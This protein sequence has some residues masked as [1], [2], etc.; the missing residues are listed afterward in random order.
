MRI[1]FL[2]NGVYPN[3]MAMCQRLHLYAKGLLEQGINPEIVFPYDNESQRKGHYEGVQFSTYRNPVFFKHFILR[4]IN[5]FFASFYYAHFCYISA[6]NYKIIFTTGFGWFTDLLIIIGAH[7][8]DAKVVIEVNENPYSPEGGR[9]DPK[10]IRKV[11]RLL[12]LNLPFRFAD[13]FIVISKSLEDLVYKFK[14]NSAQVIRVPI[15]VEDINEDGTDKIKPEYPYIFHAGALSETKDG[16]IAVFEAFAE[17]CKRT[18]IPLRFIFTINIMSPQLKRKIDRIIAE[19][20]LEDR[21]LFKGLLSVKEVDKLRASSAMAIVNK[22]SNWQNDYNFPTKLGELLIAG[23]PVIA[24]STGEMNRYL[25][26]NE[27]AFMVSANDSNAIAEKIIYILNNPDIALKIG[28][29]GRN[30]ALEKFQYTQ[31]SKMLTD[32]FNRVSI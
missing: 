12:T 19:N 21:V 9:L 14:K 28:N 1:L 6:K 27:T 25:S 29:N 16:M 18:P 3:G 32:F 30:L 15:I 24:S 20:G 23:I 11:R 10:W 4:P 5:R 22:P 13:G 17:A 8:G 7:F 26:D 2:F 31:Y